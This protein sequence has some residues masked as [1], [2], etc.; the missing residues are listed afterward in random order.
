MKVLICGDREWLNAKKIADRVKKLPAGTTVI[1]GACRGADRIA[2]NAAFN[3]G[4]TVREF[5]AQWKRYGLAAGPIRNQRMLDENPDLVI[6]FHSNLAESRGTANMLKK[7]KEK[8]VE[9]EII[10]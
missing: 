8:G 4:L 1:H 9:I 6:A 5:P 7:A 10:T 3:H 2:G